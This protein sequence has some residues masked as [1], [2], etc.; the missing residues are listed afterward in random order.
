MPD[1]RDNYNSMQANLGLLP[2]QG[3]PTGF[4]TPSPGDTALRLM[5]QATMRTQHAQ[6]M[7]GASGSSMSSM[8]A[9][10]AFGTQYQQQLQQIRSQQNVNP[11]VAQAMSMN[12]PGSPQYQ[13]GM[14]PSP[15]TMT[16]A[17]SGMFR[18]PPMGPNFAPIPPTYAPLFNLPFTPRMPSP[19]FQT[20]WEQFSSARDV[21]AER[22]ATYGMQMPSF[23]GQALGYGAA[24]YAG[25]RFGGHFGPMGAM[26]GAIG[27]GLMAGAAGIPKALGNIADFTIQ[28]TRETHLMGAGIQRMSQDWVVTGQDL[29]PQMRGLSRAAG[30]QMGGATRD[31]AA[32]R[33]FR[34]ATGGA[35]NRDD[36]MSIMKQGGQAGLFDMAQS[37]PQIKQQLQQTAVTIRQFMEL[38][39]DPNVSN[40]IR[41]MGQLRQFGM[42]QQDMLSAAQGMRAFSR[43]AGTTIGGLQQVGGLPGAMTFQQSGLSA[44]A[45]FQYGNFAAAAAR[46][47]VATG[48]VSTQQLGLLGGIQGMAQ[49]EMQGQAAFA[50]MPLFGAAMGQ[51]GAGGWG[52]RPGAAGGQMG[53]A[54]GMVNSALQSM[55]QAT[56][57]GGIGALAMFPLEQRQIQSAALSEMTPQQQMAQRYQ[58]AMQ[59][60]RFLGL[61]GEAAFAAG[62]QVAF[63]PEQAEQMMILARNPQFWRAQQQIISGQQRDLGFQ[64]RQRAIEGER[65]LGGLLGEAFDSSAGRAVRGGYHGLGQRLGALSGAISG[66]DISRFFQRR[67]AAGEGVL[68]RDFGGRGA[69]AAGLANRKDF[70]ELGDLKSRALAGGE[71]EYSDALQVQATVRD[72]TTPRTLGHGVVLD[73]VG[74]GPRMDRV[75]GALDWASSKVNYISPLDVDFAGA[76][77]GYLTKTVGSSRQAELISAEARN[78]NRSV[79]L[80]AQANRMSRRDTMTA[81]GYLDKALGGTNGGAGYASLRSAGDQLDK[82]VSDRGRYGAKP[83]VDEIKKILIK[84]ISGNGVKNA[85]QVVEDLMKNPVAANKMLATVEHFAKQQPRDPSIWLR[86]DERQIKARYEQI[87]L[88]GEQREKS[89]LS[90]REGLEEKLDLD[91]FRGS[92]S[93]EEKAVHQEVTSGTAKEFALL[94]ATLESMGIGGERNSTKL[95]ELSDKYNISAA[96]MAKMRDRASALAASNKAVAR[97]IG[98]ASSQGT[99]EDLVKYATAT[100][101]S[102]Q[103]TNWS[104]RSVVEKLAPFSDKFTDLMSKTGKDLKT[105]TAGSVAET[106]S[107]EDLKS[108]AAAGGESRQVAAMISNVK[109][110]GKGAG[111]KLEKWVAGQAGIGAGGQEVTSMAPPGGREAAKLEQSAAAIGDISAAFADFGPAAAEFREGARY[112]RDAMNSDMIKT[113]RS[114]G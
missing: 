86:Q 13:G 75:L 24:A 107:D 37:V 94:G 96:D 79:V 108:M 5:E 64:Q 23:G 42:T 26:A 44:G 27:G 112:L 82:L 62:A 6:Q 102:G 60:G 72:A 80:T 67:G 2:N 76:Y 113:L 29:S 65:A 49:R 47:A 57:R 66:N 25:A 106:F 52:L 69:A 10:S 39:N 101:E 36:L 22:M 38:T 32:D 8:G 12:F 98:S 30:L 104:K 33:Q 91:P 21:R 45:G 15:L 53:G 114:G 87:D 95:K 58:M 83:T 63:G 68:L 14:L 28:P 85:E 17:A 92:Y 78:I 19:M 4:P 88:A 74:P 11:F 110:G 35:F 20:P 56:A 93:D 99:V 90:G 73:P 40:V 89:L 31:L 3:G 9:I 59:T 43:A 111:A 54:A 46:Q 97:R 71:E 105:I 51:Y 77:G 61:K 81:A 70:G 48:A 55:N 34:G 100:S 103:Q 41:S 1:G 18:P 7:L 84:T 16:P 50:S 109:K